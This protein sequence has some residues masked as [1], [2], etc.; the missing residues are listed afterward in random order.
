MQGLK[1]GDLMA[2]EDQVA[3]HRESGGAGAHHRHLLAGGVGLG[4]QD[5]LAMVPLVV[6]REALQVADAHRLV[7]LA[8]DA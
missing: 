6:G 4:G 2:L 8:Q 7:L 1:D 5:L 3:G